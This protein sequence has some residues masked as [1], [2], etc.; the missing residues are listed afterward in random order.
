MAWLTFFL[1][2]FIGTFLGMVVLALLQ[3]AG[4]GEEEE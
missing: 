2:L 3:V 1:G 4:S